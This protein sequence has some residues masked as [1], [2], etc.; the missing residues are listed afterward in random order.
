MPVG[1]LA[2]QLVPELGGVGQGSDEPPAVEAAAGDSVAASVSATAQREVS[3]E[4]AVAAGMAR[5]AA[6]RTASQALPD[7]LHAA[8]EPDDDLQSVDSLVLPGEAEL[9]S[10]AGG[11]DAASVAESGIAEPSAADSVRA[12]AGSVAPGAPSEGSADDRASPSK[13]LLPQPPSAAAAPTADVQ[14]LPLLPSVLPAHHRRLDPMTRPLLSAAAQQESS[15]PVNSLHSRSSSSPPAMDEHVD[16]LIGDN[17]AAAQ[18]M[19]PAKISAH[20]SDVAAFAAA[21]GEAGDEPA[22]RQADS[23]PI[24]G[25]PPGDGGGFG[26]FM[27]PR[28][29]I[30]RVAEKLHLSSRSGSGGFG[31][32]ARAPRQSAAGA[33]APPLQQPQPDSSSHL[34]PQEQQSQQAED[35]SH[36]AGSQHVEAGDPQ[37]VGRGE[38][39]ARSKSSASSRMPTLDG[40]TASSTGG[41]STASDPH[42]CVC[43][44]VLTGSRACVLHVV[45]SSSS[46]HAATSP[47]LVHPLTMNCWFACQHREEEVSTPTAPTGEGTAFSFPVT[48]PS[49]PPPPPQVC[50]PSQR[51]CNG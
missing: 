49:D 38:S 20:P 39:Q 3:E 5:I 33:E 28:H 6:A 8:P 21:A 50:C 41:D 25:S 7:A 47:V 29:M 2:A 1:S 19:S 32:G 11:L 43:H 4:A 26:S 44:R 24:S 31:S 34:K 14:P 13:R 18:P 35:I 15:A 9:P 37:H 42:M 17:I 16:V 40:G 51:M 10:A 27:R 12:E 36:R 48:P 23:P 45:S 46:H 22:G 30:G